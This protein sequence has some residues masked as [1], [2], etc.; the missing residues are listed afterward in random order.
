M[1]K[2]SR[3]LH[4]DYST[5]AT[6]QLFPTQPN[7][8]FLPEFETPAHIPI[9][10][11][12]TQDL[13]DSDL[14]N[15]NLPTILLGKNKKGSRKKRFLT[16]TL[17][18]IFLITGLLYAYYQQ[19]LP[20]VDQYMHETIA[21][22]SRIYD[23]NNVLLYDAYNPSKNG[24]RVPVTLQEI[25]RIMQDAMTATEDRSFWTNSGINPASIVR[26]VL[27]RDGGGSTI[28]Q[29]LIKNLSH[30]DQHTLSRK[31]G[32]AVLALG[33]TKKYTK[34]QILTMYF[35]VASF[36]AFDIGVESAVEEYFHLQT[37]C[38]GN[39]TCVP[40]I[41]RLEYNDKGQRDPILGL[42]RASLLA[43]IPNEPSLID[44]TLSS[45]A[46]AWGLAR[47]K[48]V[49]QAMIS[50]HMSVDGQVITRAM[51]R[52]AEDIT[53]HT[54]FKSYQNV[55]RA[56]HFVDWIINQ[57]ALKLGNGNYTAGLQMFEQGGFTVHT[58]IDVNLEEYIERAIDQH[59]NKPDY[60]YYPSPLLDNQILSQA[61]NIHSGAVIVLDAKTGEIL[62]MDGSA[63]YSSTN[64][65][66]GGQYNM[67]APPPSKDP[68]NPSGRPPGAT[69]LPI[70]YM[71]AY[72]KGVS[73]TMLVPD[74]QFTYS[75][76]LTQSSILAGVQATEY[77]GTTGMYDMAQRLGITTS[78]DTGVKFVEGAEN[79][80]L[81]QMTGAYQVLAN[82]G[83]RVPPV[84]ILDIYDHNG[85]SLYHYNTL[86]PPATP[87]I[88]VQTT[89]NIT[90]SLIN[91]P[92]RTN[93]F[94]ADSQLSFADQDANCTV[95]LFC[96]YQVAVQSSNT[97]ATEDGNT[98][99]GYTPDVVVGVWVGNVDGK[100]MN[101][102]VVGSTGAVPIWHSV[103]ERALGWCG[104]Q[105]TS[106]PYFRSDNIPCGPAPHL[107][108][109]NQPTRTFPIGS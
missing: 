30:N 97:S 23:R 96:Q 76:S 91:E 49:L 92:E 53:A 6:R 79:V 52:Q 55:K 3:Y 17:I 13:P 71:A 43:G 83:Q 75:E 73:P 35:N 86:Q 19:Q 95:T 109:S 102:S 60:Q 33:L 32:E 54:D 9:P 51:A 1:S 28:T 56:P 25:P 40:G 2:K 59:L 93:T 7:G 44:P 90:R 67:A 31:F 14:P 38:Q 72:E 50:S 11:L 68:N 100:K 69:M 8:P 34:A 104:T 12:P 63:G 41:A 94:G 103:I 36:G 74:S 98:A 62:A 48:I 87:T 88:S 89:N 29:Q 106:S 70:D 65:E 21:Q 10:D 57:L 26:A 58:T 24:R 61:L 101:S 99:I 20:R 84:G 4:I 85:H 45:K 64:S 42:A 77:V 46:K 18:F 22:D 66:V 82:N 39:G 37:T 78:Q 27:T 5:V 15:A 47:Q 108:F 81:L 80:S 107:S 105:P 16:F